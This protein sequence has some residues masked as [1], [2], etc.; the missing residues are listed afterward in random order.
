MLFR[1]LH[2]DPASLLEYFPT[3][4]ASVSPSKNVDHDMS[5]SAPDTHACSRAGL[6]SCLPAFLPPSFPPPSLRPKRP[7]QSI[8][9]KQQQEGLCCTFRDFATALPHSLPHTYPHFIFG[10]VARWQNFI[11]SFP[12]IVL[13]W[14]AAIQGKE[15]RMAKHIQS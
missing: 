8:F 10:S 4:R 12:W 14:R 7:R 9:R 13:G 11:R 1:G 3:L 15:A 2:Y 6:F 5:Q